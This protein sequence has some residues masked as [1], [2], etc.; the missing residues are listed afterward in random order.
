VTSV[1]RDA[2]FNAQWLRTAGHSSSGGAEIGECFAAA[3]RIREADTESWYRAWNELGANLLGRAQESA[4]GGHHAS[5]LSGYLRAA[6]YFRAAYTF[7]MGAPLDPRVVAAYRRQRAAF[8]AATEFMRPGARRVTIPYGSASLHGY[9]FRAADDGVPRPTLIITGGYDS[10]AEEL[11]FFSGAAAVARGYTCIVFDGPGQGAAIIEDRAIFR[12]DWESVIGPVL[13]FALARREVAPAKIALLGVSFGGYL[14]PPAA[15]GEPRLAACIADPGEFAL[16][17][18]LRSRLPSFI[19]REL[20]DG[21]PL[22][23]A[24]LDF[25]LRRKMR[26]PTAG[27]ALR[28]ALWVH[29]VDS[30]LGYVRLTQDYSLEGRVAQIKCPTLIC[31]AAADEIGVTARRLYAALVSDKTFLEFTSAQ[32]AAAH[33]EAGARSVFNERA[34]DWLDAALKR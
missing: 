1:F 29:G 11:Y 28:R 10:T 34:F 21:S 16:L 22:V 3:D 9:L 5:A 19:A 12:P 27:W 24:L 32:G 20:P 2:L 30:P 15:S 31:R 26:H 6:N 8:E 25:I 13:D 4:R 14:A 17:E 18:E 33:C 23:L 7:L